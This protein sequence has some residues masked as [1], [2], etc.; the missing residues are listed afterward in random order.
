VIATSHLR[1]EAI[2]IGSLGSRDVVLDGQVSEVVRQM[3]AELARRLTGSDLEAVV[4]AREI[5]HLIDSAIALGYC[6]AVT[7]AKQFV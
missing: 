2:S 7:A 6:S 1:V 4:V 3:G 5:V